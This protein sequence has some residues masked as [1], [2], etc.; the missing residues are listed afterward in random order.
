MPFT[1]LPPA[2]TSD[3]DISRAFVHTSSLL[4]DVYTMLWGPPRD[5]NGGACNFPIALV[6]AC[7]LDGL[8][9]EI[10]PVVPVEGTDENAQFTRLRTL[11]SRMKWGDKRHHWIT[12]L[13]ATKVLW[14]EIRNPLAHNLGADTHPTF[15]RGRRGFGDTA[16]VLHMIDRKTTLSPDEVEIMT[17]WP[18]RWPVMFAKPMDWPGRP[19][20]VVSL[21]AL[22]WHVKELAWRMA[23]DEELLNEALQLR[24]KKWVQPKPEQ[25]AE[26][27]A[28][29]RDRRATRRRRERTA[30]SK[31]TR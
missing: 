25:F 14:L 12:P 9:T 8:A 2:H 26:I 31:A 3:A 10:D 28:R 17:S 29:R 27:L 6:L 13:E 15:R 21:P 5:S 1:H 4:A 23:V 18:V 7:I 24:K 11:M 30:H 19:R 16:V 20:F 22:Y